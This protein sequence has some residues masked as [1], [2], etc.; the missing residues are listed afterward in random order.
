[1]TWVVPYDAQGVPVPGELAHA[2]DGDRWHEGLRSRCDRP[3][4]MGVY[5]WNVHDHAGRVS[6]CDACRAY[7]LSGGGWHASPRELAP[8][9]TTSRATQDL[10][11]PTHTARD[12]RRKREQRIDGGRGIAKGRDVAAQVREEVRL[13]EQDA[14]GLRQPID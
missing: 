4:P 10:A 13:L 5:R 1:V 6:L 3:V 12:V 7:V 9:A 11:K 14:G 8:P 2:I